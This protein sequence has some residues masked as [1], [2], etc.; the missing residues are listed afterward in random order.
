MGRIRQSGVCQVQDGVHQ[1]E[2]TDG[3]HDLGRNHGRL[4]GSV[5]PGQEPI[6]YCYEKTSRLNNRSLNLFLCKH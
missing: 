2:G 5:R 6:P 1:E 3:R 4:Q